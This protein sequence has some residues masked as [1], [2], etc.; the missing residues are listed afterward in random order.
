MA[1]LNSL[2]ALDLGPDEAG[3]DGPALGRHV[4]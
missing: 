3:S 1:D 2:V 4:L